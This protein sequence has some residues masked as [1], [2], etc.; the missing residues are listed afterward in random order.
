MTE[1]RKELHAK[2]DQLEN[3]REELINKLTKCY[4]RADALKI[5]IYEMEQRIKMVAKELKK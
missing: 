5:K 1:K 2:Y 3:Q 4:E